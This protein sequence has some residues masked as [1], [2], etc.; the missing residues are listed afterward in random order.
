[1]DTIEQLK[2]KIEELQE[3]LKEQREHTKEM[4]QAYKIER[5]KVYEIMAIVNN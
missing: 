1:M 4:S 2:A 3:Q 5:Q